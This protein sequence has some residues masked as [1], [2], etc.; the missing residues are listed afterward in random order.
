MA[1]HSLLGQ[2]PPCHEY[3]LR[4]L[5]STL[6]SLSNSYPSRLSLQLFRP[7]AWHILRHSLAQLLVEWVISEYDRSLATSHRLLCVSNL[8]QTDPAYSVPDLA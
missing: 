2:L 3:S 6:S 4:K 1:E 8:H 5:T 7:S